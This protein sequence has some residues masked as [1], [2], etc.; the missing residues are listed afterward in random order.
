M[1]VENVGKMC[2]SL[3]ISGILYASYTTR[4][5]TARLQHY[6]RA[7]G[8][9]A[10]RLFSFWPSGHVRE[11]LTGAL[12]H[13]HCLHIYCVVKGIDEIHLLSMESETSLPIVEFKFNTCW[14]RGVLFLMRQDQQMINNGWDGDQCIA[15]N[16]ESNSYLSNIFQFKYYSNHAR[17]AALD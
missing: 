6:V 8:F 7:A 10:V 9:L 1:G 16:C 17:G 2:F 5:C 3:W 13:P 14:N 4:R 15:S 12:P 11:Q